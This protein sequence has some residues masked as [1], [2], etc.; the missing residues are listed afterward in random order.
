MIAHN[1]SG[2]RFWIL[3]DILPPESKILN[4]VKTAE[5]LIRL[6]LYKRLVDGE[7]QYSSFKCSY[8]HLGGSLRKLGNFFENQPDILE[9]DLHYDETSGDI[10]EDKRSH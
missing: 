8:N 5:R 2:L 1:G 6:E 3:I 4:L 9:R 10:W 7:P